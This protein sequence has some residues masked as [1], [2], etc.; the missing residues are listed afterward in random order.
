M[1]HRA[2][3]LLISESSNLAGENNQRVSKILGDIMT[4]L[5]ASIDKN[6]VYLTR[7]PQAAL[8]LHRGCNKKDVKK[9]YRANALKYHPDKNQD[10]DSSPVF[11]IVQS[12]YENLLLAA[13]DAP[14]TPTS[15][16]GRRSDMSDPP[17][18]PQPQPQPTQRS[19]AQQKEPSYGG[20][21]SSE[22]ESEDPTSK[23]YRLA[24]RE[25]G[26][27]KRT[28]HASSNVAHLTTDELRSVLNKF[29]FART[30][31][32]GRDELVKKYLAVNAHMKD[33]K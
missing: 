19:A 3:A 30:E 25:K 6:V 24:G 31:S 5:N 10:C 13:P 23:A 4:K 2:K 26:G 33:S 8:K 20:L 28:T 12:A 16:A 17:K 9:A 11:T 21:Y 7:N 29:G 14:R 1:F 32:M 18:P 15:R 22:R 27:Q